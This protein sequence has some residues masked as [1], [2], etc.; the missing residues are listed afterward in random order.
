VR[1]KHYV[2]YTIFF[3]FSFFLHA[4]V[5]VATRVAPQD[6]GMLILFIA[7]MAIVAYDYF[8][9]PFFPSSSDAFLLR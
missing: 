1:H 6:S 7:K 5:L 2:V 3:D 9:A 4:H 8:S